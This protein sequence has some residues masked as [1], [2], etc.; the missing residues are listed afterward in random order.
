[1]VARWFSVFMAIAPFT[2]VH[3]LAAC[4]GGA[5]AMPSGNRTSI[6]ARATASQPAA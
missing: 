2:A 3:L 6:T 5:T 1:M 4:G